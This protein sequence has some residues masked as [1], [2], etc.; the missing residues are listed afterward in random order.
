NLFD[1]GQ[2]GLRGRLDIGE[3]LFV[4]VT[5]KVALGVSHEVVTID[6]NDRFLPFVGQPQITTGGLYAL[7]TNIGRFTHNQFAVL[8]ELT[9]AFGVYITEAIRFYASYNLLY[10]SDAVRVGDQIDHNVNV[11]FDPRSSAFNP[12]LG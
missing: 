2:V 10:L 1:G 6:G 9:V 11:H 7:S 8:P 12:A 3:F 4:D 5:G